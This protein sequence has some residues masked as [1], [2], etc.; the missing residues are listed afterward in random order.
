[1]KKEFVFHGKK[2]EELNE[3]NIKEFAALLTARPRRSLLR[4]L[5][6]QQKILVAKVKKKDKNIKTHCRN[7]I[8]IPQ[9]VDMT[10]RVYNG[11]E[12]VILVILPEMLGHY[13]GEFVM[14]RKKVG[15]HA[16]GI[17]ATRSSASLSV[18]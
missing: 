1:M 15:H 3:L 12:F 14:T 10:M 16:P 2:L 7:M 17:G 13:L 18:K 6:D 8:I 4:G 5:T 11:K 9:M